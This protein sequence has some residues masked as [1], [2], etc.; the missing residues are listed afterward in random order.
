MPEV[1]GEFPDYAVKE[2]LLPAGV[3]PSSEYR[4]RFEASYPFL[5]EVVD[6][7]Y[8]RWGNFTSFQRT[9]GVLRLLSLVVHALK[10][11]ELPYISLADFELTNQKVRRELLKHIGPEYDSVIAADITGQEAGARK[12]DGELGA[13]YRGTLVATTVFLYSFSGGAERG[14]R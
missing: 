9:R 5:P 8:Q 7:L 4:Q 6:I 11:R 1:V 13:A 10:E 14:P 12:V 3:E 2:S